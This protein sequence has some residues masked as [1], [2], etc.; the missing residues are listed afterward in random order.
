MEGLQE[1]DLSVEVQQTSKGNDS[2]DSNEDYLWILPD[3][4]YQSFAEHFLQKTEVQDDSFDSSGRSGSQEMASSF[5]SS[6]G[7]QYLLDTRLEEIKL[8]ETDSFSSPDLPSSINEDYAAFV[9][10]EKFKLCN[11][12]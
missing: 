5:E 8:K 11:S 4:D 9:D 12:N 10:F 7:L 3:E 1:H 2:E 6:S